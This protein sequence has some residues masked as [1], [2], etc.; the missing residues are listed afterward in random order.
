MSLFVFKF[1]NYNF[2]PC[3]ITE[4]ENLYNYIANKENREE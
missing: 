3:N 2:V 4:W 1:S